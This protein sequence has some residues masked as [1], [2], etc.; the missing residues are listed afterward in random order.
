M[1]WR[2]KA[3]ARLS[4]WTTKTHTVSRPTS[5]ATWPGSKPGATRETVCGPGARTSRSFSPGAR[6][7]AWSTPRTSTAPWST[8]TQRH[9][10]HRPKRDGDLLSLHTQGKKLMTIA[11]YC[12]WLV[13]E[14]LLPVDPA[15]ELELPRPGIRLPKA[16]LTT[17]EAEAILA[18]PDVSTVLGL[19]DRA[20]LEVFYATWDPPLRTRPIEPRARRTQ[21]RRALGPATAR[22]TR[23]ASCPS[24]SEP[25]P[26]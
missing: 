24:A 9:L 2:Y 22:A 13:R 4:R 20:M 5:A 10:S 1:A 25:R 21:P 15:A 12:K 16:V 11:K 8:C 6:S 23:T 19:R 17:E 3:G 7:A 26:G 14:R 18:I